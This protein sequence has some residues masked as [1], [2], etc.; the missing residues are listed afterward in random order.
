MDEVWKDI[1]GYED[2]YQVSD[3][4]RVRHMPRRIRFVSKK[5]S[6][7]W[8]T[9][10]MRVCASNVTREGYA[11]AHLQVDRKRATPTVHALVLAAFVGPRPTDLDVN[12][13]NGLKT[14]NRLANLEYVT[15]T[16]NHKHAVR[17]GLNTQAMPVVAVLDGLV[18]E[19]YPSMTEAA[20]AVGL[21]IGSIQY[22][23]RNGTASK[24]FTWSRA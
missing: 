19:R 14:D 3:Q 13:I 22:A 5:G 17:T 23:V 11:I 16:E 7:S 20:R 1:P 15:R 21:T 10:A 18:V 8:R 24:G 6:E 2:V 9:T 4:G 12:H